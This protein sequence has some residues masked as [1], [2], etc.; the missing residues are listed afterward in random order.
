MTN[1]VGAVAAP[2]DVAGLETPVPP[3]MLELV[4]G[5]TEPSSNQVVTKVNT[6]LEVCVA[7]VRIYSGVY[8]LVGEFNWNIVVG[9]AVS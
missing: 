1:T 5:A 6:V 3:E 2:I 9:L 8:G 4:P 7:V